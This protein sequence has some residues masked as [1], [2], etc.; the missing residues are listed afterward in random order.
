[1]TQ[2]GTFSYLPSGSITIDQTAGT[3]SFSAQSFDFGCVVN[4]LEVAVLVPETCT[5]TVSSTYTDGKTGPTAN[6]EFEGGEALKA[7]TLPDT[8][9]GLK[10]IVIAVSKALPVLSALR[11]DNF[12]HCNTK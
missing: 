2:K 11:M 1:M 9:T 4:T 7:V 10:S 12:K 3:K 6:F 5:I 8:F